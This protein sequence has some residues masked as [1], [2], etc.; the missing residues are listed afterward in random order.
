ML[1][2]EFLIG[3]ALM[4]AS[5]ALAKAPLAT[6]Q[7][8]GAYRRK[9]GSFQVTALQDGFAGLNASL[10]SG[11]K[12]EIAKV[13]AA[14]GQSE[15]LPTSVNSFLVN[16]GSKLVLVDTGTGSSKAFGPN[17]GRMINNLTAIGVSPSQIDAVI[18]THAHTDHI[19]G[20]LTA[21]GKA[22]FKN[23]EII[24]N[25]VEANFWA[26]DTNMN[27]APEAMKGLFKS[28]RMSLA[29]YGKQ[30][31][32]V[33]AGAEVLPGFVMEAASGHTPGHC[34]VRVASDKE[35]ILLIGDIL[36]NTT[37]HTALPSTG[38]GFDM[39][40]AAAAA[41]RKKVFDMIAAD[42]MLVGG[43]HIAF[44]GFGKVLKDGNAFKYVPSEW[45]NTL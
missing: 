16:T 10:F 40:A 28:A 31:R 37:I 36:H 1:R 44:P 12:A 7:V 39:D 29:P 42:K 25:E 27:K 41:S 20:L 14:N 18:L 19:E 33:K 23:A 35:Q 2:R 22:R 43:V 11:D 4:G 26:D 13:L 34:V 6:S 45:T 9:L 24:I 21:S 3:A 38:F 8:A 5:S 15:D 30:V 17:L 32:K